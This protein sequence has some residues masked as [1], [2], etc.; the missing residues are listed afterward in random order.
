MQAAIYARVSTR[1][2]G[3]EVENQLSELRRFAQTQGWDMAGEYIDHETGKTADRPEFRRLFED[4]ARRRFDV[5]L[6]WSL[7]RLT[8]EG[9][10]QTLQHLQRLSSYGVGFRSLT[11]PYL[12]SCGVFRDVIIALLSALARQEAI[13][14]SERVKAGLQ[15]ARSR[16]K[17]LGR[18]KVSLDANEVLRLRAEGQ[19]FGKI[20]KAFGCGES[21]IRRLAK[22]AA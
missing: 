18:P 5:V 1:D 16:G 10:L 4:A 12:D 22:S 14:L 13:R 11:E 15:T 19:S 9:V 17:T 21:T 20:A 6:F 7:D 8:R 2:K 3:Q